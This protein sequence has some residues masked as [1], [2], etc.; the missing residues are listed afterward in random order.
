MTQRQAGAHLDAFFAA[1]DTNKDGKLTKQEFADFAWKRIAKADAQS[2]TKD[3]L[4]AFAKERFEKMHAERRSGR[5][6]GP[7]AGATKAKR[8]GAKSAKPAK[9]SAA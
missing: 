4:K 9:K 1:A 2:V 6:H 5:R 8:D 7:H 3:E